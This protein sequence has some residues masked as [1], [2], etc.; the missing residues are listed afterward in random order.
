MVVDVEVEGGDVGPIRRI[1]V[2]A[3]ILGMVRGW[4]VVAIALRDGHAFHA[5]RVLV[6]LSQG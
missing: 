3:S 2:H 4:F 6:G 5:R 1:G